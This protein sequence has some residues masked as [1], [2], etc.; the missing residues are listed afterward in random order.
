MRDMVAG[1]VAKSHTAHAAALHIPAG[2][3]GAFLG[4]TALRTVRAL[5]GAGALTLL[6]ALYRVLNAMRPGLFDPEA[7]LYGYL[8]E[9]RRSNQSGRPLLMGYMLRLTGEESASSLHSSAPALL[10]ALRPR[11]SMDTSPYLNQAR[12]TYPGGISELDALLHLLHPP[13]ED[14][15]VGEVTIFVVG[16]GEAPPRPR[17]INSVYDRKRAACPYAVVCNAFHRE[18][19]WWPSLPPATHSPRSRA[20][21]H[22]SPP[23]PQ[24][25]RR[26]QHGAGPVPRASGH[27]PAPPRRL[28]PRR[29]EAGPGGHPDRPLRGGTRA[30]PPPSW[31][32]RHRTGYASSCGPRRSPPS[33]AST[34][35]GSPRR[36]ARTAEDPGP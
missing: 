14:L 10:H 5:N 9:R 27:P 3:V 16:A 8:M 28:N 17:L 26:P 2:S 35:C 32:L 34:L 11:L 22:L 18:P 6:P 36:P 20:Q 1:L 19:T 33:G 4:E 7:A 13:D 25:H 31:R 23:L 21:P 12:A 30:P 15:E 29:P 24:D